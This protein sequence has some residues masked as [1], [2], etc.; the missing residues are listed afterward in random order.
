MSDSREKSQFFGRPLNT[1]R[2]TSSLPSSTQF[3]TLMTR[4]HTRRNSVT[5]DSRRITGV[6]RPELKKR[7]TLESCVVQKQKTGS[8]KDVEEHTIV[9]LGVGGVG[10]TGIFEPDSFIFNF[11]NIRAMRKDLSLVL[12]C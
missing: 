2:Q 5:V 1:T 6:S 12:R 10:K 3:N 9:M 4:S 11:P 8:P 7:A